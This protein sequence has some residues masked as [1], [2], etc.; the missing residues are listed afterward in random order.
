MDDIIVC[1]KQVPNT[2]SIRLHP[3][4]H[5]IIREGVPSILNPAD[6]YALNAALDCKDRYGA[7]VGVVT[8][9]PR[10]AEAVLTDSLGQGAD[11][12]FLLSDNKLTGSDTLA[13]AR[14]L[15]AFI[16]QTP[17]KNIFCGQ[18]TIDSAT[19]HIGPSLAEL[20]ERPQVNYVSEI[21]HMDLGR[22]RVNARFDNVGQ[23]I[24][25]TLPAVV[26]FIN[27]CGKL[28]EKTKNIG[29]E[30]IRVLGLKE[31]R[32]EAEIV[33]IEG[34]PTRVVSICMDENAINYV[35]VDSRLPAHERIS[36]ILNGGMKENKDRII[37][38]DTSKDSIERMISALG[39]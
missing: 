9:G 33:G 13:T 20:F 12:A 17:Y 36:R 31:I 32:V 37:L 25:V 29:K 5:T 3:K 24:D 11:E 21:I 8:M 39:I 2:A 14:V 19:G 34:S 35:A 4:H 7:K 15:H 22:M 27:Y 10:Q 16:A 1:V 28:R 6:E 38:K 18:E 30:S 26:T 23:I